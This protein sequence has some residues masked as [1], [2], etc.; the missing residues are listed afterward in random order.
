MDKLLRYVIENATAGKIDKQTAAYMLKMLKNSNTKSSEDIAIIG[1]SAKLPSASTMEEFWDNIINGADCIRTFPE[2]RKRDI[3]NYVYFSKLEPYGKAKYLNGAFLEEV[4]KFDYKLFKLT[5]KEASL[6]DPYQRMFLQTVWHAIEDSGY[7]GRRLEKSKTGVFVGFANNAKDS[8]QKMI[9]DVEPTLLGLSAVGNTTSMLPSRI[10]YLLDLKGPTMVLDTACSSS[11]VAVHTACN[12]LKNGDCDMAIAGGIRINLLPLDKDYT[13]TGFESSDGRTRTFDDE[14]DGSGIGEGIVALLLKPLSKAKKDCD[15]IYAVIKGS[16]INQDGAS[17]GITAPNPEA[18]TD[19]IVNAWEDAGIDPNTISYIEAHGTGTKLGDPIEIQGLQRAFR[20]YTDKKQFC[21]ISTVKTN[22]GHLYE[23]SGMVGILKA[24]MALRN[25]VIPPSIY[26][27]KPNSKINFSE[28]PVY[29]NTRPRVWEKSETLRRCGVSSFGFSGTNCHLV[30]EEAPAADERKNMESGLQILTLSGK[31]KQVLINLLDRY[32]RFTGEIKGCTLTDICYTAN[33]GRGHYNFRLALIVKNEEDLRKQINDLIQTGLDKDVSGICFGEHRIIPGSKNMRVP[34][35]ITEWEKEELSQ[36]AAMMVESFISAGKSDEGILKEI[37]LLYTSGADID[38]KAFYHDE[39]A[40]KVNIPLYPFE[41]VRCWLDIP[42]TIADS[43]IPEEKDIYFILGWKEEAAKQDDIQA[44]TGAVLMLK[45]EWSMGDELVSKFRHEGR[46]VIE[47]GMGDS[48]TKINEKS[49]TIQGIEKDYE[50]LVKDLQEKEISQVIHMMSIAK[51]SDVTGLDMLGASQSRGVYSLFYLTRALLK[52]GKHNEI[53]IHIVSDNVNRVTGSE[54]RLNPENATIMGLGKVIGQE[55]PNITCRGIDIDDSTSIDEIISEINL[56]AREYLTAYRKGKRFVEEFREVNIDKIEDNTVEIKEDGVYVITGGTG[57][58]GLEVAKK[59]AWERKVKL[60]FTSLSGMPERD[61]WNEILSE[62]K[63]RKLIHKIKSIAEI[64]N[65]G[66][67][68]ICYK[69]DVSNIDEMKQVFD[70]LREKYG[71]INGII[72]SAGIA[73]AGFIIRKDEENFRKVLDPKVRGTWII[74]KLTEDCDLDFLVLFSSGASLLGEAGQGDYVAANSYLDT[75]A[76]YRN[77]HGKNTLTINWVSW[78]DAGMSVEFGINIDTVFKA[79]PAKQAVAAFR[80]IIGKKIPRVLIGELNY[81]DEFI[82]ILVAL[83][84]RMSD[85][86]SG[87]LNAMVEISK[88]KLGRRIIT[89]D[90][91]EMAVID[92]KGKVTFLPR[93]KKSKASGASSTSNVTLKGKESEDYSQTEEKIAKIF[94]QILGFNEIGVHDSFFELGGDS[95]M[96]T[97]MHRIIE[98]EFPGR[99]KVADLFAYTSVYN[100]AEYI[101]NQSSSEVRNTFNIKEIRSAEEEDIAIIGMAGMFPGAESLEEFWNNIVNGLDCIKEFPRVR[102]QDL[103]RYLTYSMNAEESELNYFRGAYF[104]RIDEFDYKF[105]RMS[106]KEASLMDPSQRLLLQN[107]WHVVEDSGYGGRKLAG[108]NTGIYLGFSANSTYQR[109]IIDVEPQ[110][111]PIS[112]TGNIAAIMPSRIAYMLDLRGPT[113]LIDTACSAS[114]VAI[115]LA[116]QA[117]KSG[118]CEMAIA[119]GVKLHSMPIDKDYMKIGVE[120][121]DGRTKTFDNEADGA[122]IG[123]GIGSVFLKPLKKALEDG[124]SIHAVIKGSAINQDG[125]SIGLTAPNPKSQ[126]DVIIKAWEASGIDPAAISYIEAHGTGT[127]LGDPIEIDGLQRAFAR[128]TDKKQFCAIST[129]KTN[130]GHL[131]ESAGIAGVIKAVLALKHRVIPPAINFSNPN[132]KI[133]FNDSPI[134]VNTLPRF[135]KSQE[136][137]RL[138]GIS[139]FGLSGTNSHLLLEEAPVIVEDTAASENRYMEFMTL[140]AANKETLMILV[141]EYNDF[142]DNVQESDFRKICFTA[143]T[144]REHLNHRLVM[145][146]KCLDDLKEKILMLTC[147][148]FDQAH[149]YGVFYGEHRL[150]SGA[151]QTKQAGDITETEMLEMTRRAGTLMVSVTGVQE[152]DESEIEEIC[153]LYISGAD[154]AWELLYKGEKMRRINLPTYPFERYRCW[155]DIPDTRMKDEIIPDDMRYFA[156][157]WKP[158]ELK[159]QDRVQAT[160]NV[161]IFMDNTGMGRKLVQELR[162]GGRRVIEIEEGDSFQKVEEDKYFIQSSES[163]FSDLLKD[164]SAGGLK[165]IIHMSTLGGKEE[166]ISLDELEA[167]QEIGV[168]SLLHLVRATAIHG[169]SEDIDLVLVSDYADRVSG[170]E[171]RL[172]PQNSTLFGLGKV[173]RKEHLNLKCR[174]IDIDDN[175]TVNELVT[176]LNSK[177]EAFIT[178]YRGTQ[179]YIEEFSSFSLDSAQDIPFTV[180]EEGAY[181][182]TGGTGGIGIEVSKYLAGGNR[183]NIAL[184]NRTQMPEREEWENFL[185]HG[186]NDALCKKISAIKEIEALGANVILFDADVADIDKMTAIINDIRNQYGKINGIIHTAGIANDDLLINKTDEGFKKVLSPKVI[187][188]WVLEKLTR[189]DDLDFFIMFS[190]VAT[191]FSAVGQGD[192]VAANSYLDSFAAYLNLKAR[193]ALTINWTTWKETGMAAA[194]GFKFNTVFK[195]LPTEIGIDGFSNVMT[196]NLGRILIGELNLDSVGI[197][198]LEHSKVKL[199]DLIA[200]KIKEYKKVLK[201]K[202]NYEKSKE[203]KIA[204]EV[205]LTGRDSGD[206]TGTEKIIAKICRDTLGFDEIDIYDNFFELGADSILLM[207]IY[208]EVEKLFPGRLT[209]VDLFE[210]S[211][212]SRLA[213]YIVD[214]DLKEQAFEE[215]KG[216]ETS[217]NEVGDIAIIGMAMRFPMAE[218]AEEFWE[219]IINKTDCGAN[220]PEGRKDDINRFVKFKNVPLNAIQY[221]PGVYLEQIDKFD[222]NFFRLSPKEVST[223][224]PHHRLFLQTA[225]EAIEDAGYGG[226]KIVGTNTGVYLGFANTSTYMRILSDIDPASSS[227]ALVGNTAAV[228][229]GRLSYL[230]NLKGPSLVIDSACSASLTSVHLACKSIKNGDCDMAI[231]GGV[232]LTMIPISRK[233]ETG[234]IGMESSDGKTRT[235]DDGSDGTGSGEGVAAILLKPLSIAIKDNDN[236]YAVI[237]GSATNQ[238]GSSAG[239]TAPNPAAQEEV[240]VKAW[241]DAGVEPES[242]TYIEAHGTGTQLGDPIEITGIKRA[243]ERFTN[244]KQFCAISSV[245]SNIGHLS[246][247]AG[248]A[249][250]IKTVMALRS[251]T[252]PPHNYFCRPNRKIDFSDSPVYVNTTTRRWETDGYPR[253]CGISGFGMSGTNCHIVLEEAPE[254]DRTVTDNQELKV[255]TISARS[256]EALTNLLEAYKGCIRNRVSSE[257]GNFCYTANTGRGHYS[258]R[259]AIIARNSHEL[260]SKLDRLSGLDIQNNSDSMC[261]YGTHKLAKE[262]STGKNDTA[263]TERGKIEINQAAGEKTAQFLNSGKKDED[264]LKEI[265][266]LYTMGADIDWDE[267][268]TGINPRKVSL[269]PYAFEQNRCWLDIPDIQ[270]SEEISAGGQYYLPCWI[271]QEHDGNYGIQEHKSVLIFTDAK[272]M[273]EEIANRYRTEGA[274]VIEVTLDTVYTVHNSLKYSISGCEDDYGKL[275]NDLKD[276]KFCQIIHMMSITDIDHM[277]CLSK[278]EESQLRGVYSLFYLTKAMVK[279]GIGREIDLAILSAYVNEVTKQEDRIIP[280]GSTLLGLGKVIR[281]ENPNIACRSIDIDELTDID[282]IMRELETASP[283]YL[284][285]YR[286][287][288]RYIEEI[289]DF[290]VPYAQEHKINFKENGVYIITGGIGGIAL[291]IARGMASENNVKLVLI[292]RSKLPPK[293]QWNNLP[294]TRE[295]RR[296]AEKIGKIKE[297]EAMGAEISYYSADISNM[298]EVKDI[299]DTVREKYGQVDGVVHCAGVAGDGFLFRKEKQVFDSVLNPKVKGTWILDHVT[300]KDDLDF[301]VMCSSIS[302]VFCEP[303][304]GD[305]AAANSYLDSYTV[306]RNRKGKKTLAIN[307]VAWKETGMAVDYGVNFDGL[308]KVLP[309]A[310]AINAFFETL[311]KE[312]PRIIIGEINQQGTDFLCALGNLPIKL[313]Y[314][315]T[316]LVEKAKELSDGSSAKSGVQSGE[317]RLTGKDG[318]GYSEIEGKLAVMFSEVLGFNEINI[319]DSFFELGG[320]SILLGRLHALIEK[321]FP[322]KV[323]LI[324]LF[325][326]SSIDRLS[327]YISE[328]GQDDMINL[329]QEKDVEKELGELISDMEDGNISI[330]EALESLNK[331]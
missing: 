218:N 123:E 116:C 258:C 240:I 284:V 68:V 74:D 198:L 293:E 115:H 15:N 64:E 166:I 175:T 151:R 50:E 141:K 46:D 314:K 63:D 75:Y 323:K 311:N 200:I 288:R 21:A 70:E 97:Q 194:H 326:Y 322:G 51:D 189:D 52:F 294:Y 127:K 256:E 181:I 41:S 55:Y 275:L 255:L 164:I 139:A 302:S 95:V 152:P 223:T 221:N 298:D 280:E 17:I 277:D 250:L 30:L 86:L 282:C 106:P 214:K 154:I 315:L 179:R 92:E 81:T 99:V 291:S 39:K 40:R 286:N 85:Y 229:A 227:T 25:K 24:V 2:V 176:E 186:G 27:S 47:V 220:F 168:L 234:G 206:Y 14:S 112:M 246:E 242:V 216:R 32:S 192:Y 125:K 303:G 259:L 289:R 126:E 247:A 328:D 248:I 76:A 110:S 22:I 23:S 33:T 49:Y 190:S 77:L 244:K 3:D 158:E 268:Y 224:D 163:D 306:Y 215:I 43:K 272:G 133:D 36:K 269:P 266:R 199:S 177:G 111:M 230:L 317:I 18:Q 320:D 201:D 101:V 182:I 89:N 312:V 79:I 124:D 67:E 35:D 107:M 305:Y 321:E 48:F 13:K 296:I 257:T 114:V 130:I 174:C 119:G 329:E 283:T 105:F 330:E 263:L 147:N 271:E 120:S 300:E 301:F 203:N 325:E 241:Q 73:G 238:D 143:N 34:G 193:R 135:W 136:T 142:L 279:A 273:W 231:A 118:D 129:V 121:S 276:K 252:I 78:K 212:I 183:I 84:Y 202:K 145:K 217:E 262:S 219:N 243:F 197:S 236:I 88:D 140:S 254:I 12:S 167:S 91:Y 222:Y 249:G 100:L 209:V 150:I 155:L 173:L 66:S 149:L 137:S 225:W 8:Y 188:T 261:Y 308:F 28:S 4:D 7:G 239:I 232:R 165:Q 178:A 56:G 213:K 205:K 72:H 58:I 153:R 38:W 195:T 122:G 144:G 297:I 65:T 37:C 210:Y 71:R 292:S 162:A 196:K 16:A 148:G 310:K 191:M 98:K 19:V 138:C 208:N 113:M 235:F 172:K 313:S 96:L 109:M 228:A 5:P 316:A 6:M 260:V 62:G 102:K 319:H 180:K 324:D 134:Y 45:D 245:K 93:S 11:L 53:S 94:S 211:T 26:F 104:D 161:L 132:N 267:L 309:T 264:L 157:E 299:V 171:E 87:K 169:L 156:M 278:L 1:I 83:P 103:D 251:K 90:G 184:I 331:M 237:K 29:V 20:K 253:R 61:C 170:N 10:S 57:G 327:Q 44:H 290:E 281:Q 185:S 285:A 9:Y 274:E 108:S 295:G 304:Q 31:S 117:I 54:E 131:H 80:E 204:G 42:E 307:W 159:L 146:V 187:G 318:E 270:E 207:K 60:A 160:G 69:A 128:Y 265:C 226:K 82:P 287:G 59:I 233:G